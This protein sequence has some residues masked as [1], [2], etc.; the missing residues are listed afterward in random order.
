MRISFVLGVSGHIMQLYAHS[1][2]SSGSLAG[3]SAQS[4]RCQSRLLLSVRLV[5][6]VHVDGVL[7]AFDGGS[8]LPGSFFPRFAPLDGVASVYVVRWGDWGIWWRE[9]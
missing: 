8:A 3:Q 1:L 2:V 9:V 6:I 4:V 7:A 5:G